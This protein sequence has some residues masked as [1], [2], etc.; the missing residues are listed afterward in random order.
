MLVFQLPTIPIFQ[1]PLLLPSLKLTCPLKIDG[2]NTSFQ[3]QAV[4]FRHNSQAKSL[5]MTFGTETHRFH[6][7]LSIPTIEEGE[8]NH[9]L[10]VQGVPEV[11]GKGQW[12]LQGR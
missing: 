12:N 7:A 2:W 8:P 1:V 6:I 11:W 5:H 3:G 10:E 4:S 9:G